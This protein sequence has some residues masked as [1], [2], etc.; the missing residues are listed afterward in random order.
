MRVAFV[1]N[2]LSAGG[3]ELHLL[4]LSRHLREAG[5]DVLVGY[6]KEV[7]DT[8]PLK[9]DFEAFGIPVTDFK[10]ERAV[11]PRAFWRALRWVRQVRPDLVHT[12]LPRADLLG[13]LC[14]LSNPSLPWVASV[15]AVYRRRSW[16]GRR[17]LP[18]LARVW[19][20]ADAVVAISQ[21][22]ADWLVNDMRV[23]QEKV[24]VVHYGI[25]LTPFV[26]A[27][28]AAGKG[29]GP[30]VG[31]MGRLDPDKGHDVFLRAA[32]VVA[33]RYPDARFL[34]AGHDPTGYRPHLQQLIAELGLERQA[35]LVGFVADVPAFMAELDVFVLAS[36]TEGFGQVLVEAMAAG[37]PVVASAIAPITE[38]VTHGVTGLLVPP[39][40]PRSL[41][42]AIVQL[43][44]NPNLR[45]RLAAQARQE[46]LSRFSAD[47]MCRKM[48]RVY[49]HV[50]VGREG[51]RAND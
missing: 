44:E 2:T 27:K 15:H 21:A 47:V 3:A 19:R 34:I 10:G 11:S 50:L 13:W 20:Q 22:V 14:K 37:R 16:R 32:R 40:D 51:G 1:I 38:I 25:D 42:E 48:L 31:T 6:F 12:H 30:T 7:P 39:E 17:T 23:P 8:R 41:A 36:R 5:V 43:L 49:R 29:P 24:H 18:L 35:K 28:P 4:T 45:A 26:Q 46:A 9:G 33:E